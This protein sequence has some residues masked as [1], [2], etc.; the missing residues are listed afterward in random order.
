MG[1]SYERKYI[2][3]KKILVIGSMNMDFV[4]KV[5]KR[6]ETGETVLGESLS[7]KPGGKGANQAYAAAKLGGDVT[8]LGAVGDDA[9]GRQLI[10]DL[11]LVGVHTEY[12]KVIDGINT[13]SAFVTVNEE[14]DNSIT[15]IQG[16]NTAVDRTYIDSA[17]KV[18]ENHD[19]VIFQL[20]IP[21]DTV[22]YG[23]ELAKSMNKIVIL[24]PAPVQKLS[25]D[26]FK[27]LNVIKPNQKEL[28]GLLG[29]SDISPKD[30][31][32]FLKTMGVKNAIVT[33][34]EN[35]CELADCHGN[36]I[37]IDAKKAKTIDTT[38][39]GDCFTAAMAYCIADGRELRDALEFAKYAS[40]IS[41]TRQGAQPSFPTLNEVIESIK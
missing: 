27:N 41:V 34:G 35:G 3:M 29:R 26:V 24:D 22:E 25:L 33:L 32:D 9:F 31:V 14:G 28:A 5:K 19:I 10:D 40:A 2:S 20:E 11:K 38:G 16:A 7:L 13:G 37:H 39:A 1:K 6:P 30:G 15:V 23:I 4:I 12:I 8:M 18:I 36:R 17:R 21:I